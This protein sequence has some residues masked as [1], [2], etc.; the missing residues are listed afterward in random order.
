MLSEFMFIER[1]IENSLAIGKVS[2]RTLLV[3][4]ANG[5]LLRAYTHALNII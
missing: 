5:S 2:E 3:D 1:E 4:D